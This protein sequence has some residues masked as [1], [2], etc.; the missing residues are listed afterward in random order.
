MAV[1]LDGP[2]WARRGTVG[3]RDGLPFEVLCEMLGWPVVERVWLPSWL[4]DASSVID[5][6]VAAVEAAPET[7]ASPVPLP[8]AAVESFRGVAA[9][10]ASVTSV[11]VPAKPAAAKKPAKPAGLDGEATFV[12]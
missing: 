11:A 10:R 7:V 6:L 2:S 4:A 9:L 5:R 12:P 3:D 1:L 8:I